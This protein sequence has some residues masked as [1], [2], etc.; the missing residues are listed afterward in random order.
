M[1]LGQLGGYRLPAAIRDAYG[2]A[3]AQE[4]ADQLGVTKKP[5]SDLGGEADAAYQSLK[6]GDQ[7]PARELLVQRLGVSASNADA[8]LA[9][10]PKL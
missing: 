9:K 1:D 6:Q 3:T 8:A 2:V 10:L 4:L 7:G 5:T